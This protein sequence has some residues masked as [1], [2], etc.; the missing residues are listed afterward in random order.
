[1]AG[2][3]RHVRSCLYTSTPDEHFVIDVHP[4]HRQVVVLSPCSGHGFKFTPVIGEIA[5]D[6]ALDGATMH[7][8]EPFALAR[9]SG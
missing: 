3:V 5:A 8:I 9:L 2:P 4:E 1:M 7:P 6:L